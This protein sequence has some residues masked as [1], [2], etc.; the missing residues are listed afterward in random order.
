M[1]KSG[2]LQRKIAIL[3]RAIEHNPSSTD[4]QFR[5]LA[6][7]EDIWERDQLDKEWRQFAFAHP[8]DVHIWQRYL[9]YLQS[10]FSGFSLARIHKAYEKYF[11]VS[12]SISEGTFRSHPAKPHHDDNFVLALSCLA[13]MWMQSGHQEKAVALYQAWT[14]F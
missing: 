9:F 14:I 6:M 7:C 12:L 8:N 4:L 1:T 13:A 11:S 10:S 2:L 3:E 5:R